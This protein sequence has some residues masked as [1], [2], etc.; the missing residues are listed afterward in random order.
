MG[1]GGSN[2]SAQAPQE[3]KNLNN[4]SKKNVGH[5]NSHKL[6]NIYILKS[7]CKSHNKLDSTNRF[8][9][10][11]SV[12]SLNI[13]SCAQGWTRPKSLRKGHRRD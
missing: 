10:A 8:R 6:G 3:Q 1:R 9:L 5:V 11:Q 7:T 2:P 12:K 13:N 4:K